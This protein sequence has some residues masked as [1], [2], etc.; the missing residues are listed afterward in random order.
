LLSAED[1]AKLR[2]LNKEESTLTTE[3]GNKLLAASNA[4]ALVVDHKKKL[5]G[6]SD[7]EI[8]AA[9]GAAKAA[10]K[11]GKYMLPLQNTTQ[12]P[13]Q[14][15]L[16]DRATREALFKASTTRAEHDDANDTRSIIQRLAVLR[17][18]KAKLLGF[19]N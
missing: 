18:Q 1:K 15:S 11:D 10:G 13:A 19:P 16:S 14:A 9:A 12:Q 17:A 5:A 6:L 7:A 4:G 3:F 8:A 2:E